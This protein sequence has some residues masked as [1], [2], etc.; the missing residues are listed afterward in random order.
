[1]S[2]DLSQLGWKAFQD[3]AAAV[4]AEVLK[5][6]VQSFLGSNDGGRDGAFLG[7]WDAA[8]PLAGKSTIQ[9][10]FLGKPGANLTLADL[11]DELP[12]AQKLAADGLADDYIVMTNAGVS[13]DADN[14]IC[15]AFESVG[16]KQCRTF[17]GGWIVKQLIENPRLRMLVPRVYGIGDLSHVITGH[18]YKQAQAILNSMGSDLSCFV[19]TDAYR[20]AVT[21]LQEHGFVILLGDPASGKSTIAAILALGAIDD[22]CLG[23]LKINSPD[24][25]SLW[26]PGEK[27]FL[28]VDDAFGPNNFDAARMA[29]WNAQLGAL[30]AAVEGGARVVFTSRNYI[31]EAARPHLK[32]SAFPLFKES[33]V[34][35]NVHALSDEERAQMLYNHVRRVQPRE[36]RQRLKPFLPAVAS[37][38][39]FLPETA[40]RLGDPLFTKNLV[41]SRERL[42]ELVEHPVEFLA[43]VLEQ[44]DDPSRAAVALVFLNS[45]SGVPSPIAETPAMQMVTRLTGVTH[46]EI[47]RAMQ[48]LN[49][50]ITRLISEDDGD[51]WI[52]RHPTVADAFATLV[53]PSPE[54]IELYVHGAKLDRLL[55]DAACRQKAAES[56]RIRIPPAL[57]PALIERLK[58]HPLDDA[59]MWFL[60]SQCEKAFLERI[61]DVRP[62]ILKWAEGAAASELVLGGRVLFAAM[63]SWSLFPET[64][65]KAMVAKIQEHSISWLNAKPLTNEVT[66]QIFK[67][68][69]F[70]AY[71]AAFKKAWLS[72]IP[73]VFSEFG[74]YSS[75]DEVGLYNEFKENLQAAQAYFEMED[76]DE[77]DE[78]YAEIDAHIESLGGEERSHGGGWSSASMKKPESSASGT[79][80]GIFKDVDD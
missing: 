39:A 33:Q 26:H 66:R 73:S 35:V 43:E 51:R 75:E 53:G 17:D 50:S 9:C 28:W 25:L 23:A 65:R 46:A 18:G 36:I 22:G 2:F 32:T 29:G 47:A 27:Q 70:A 69:E 20:S 79:A 72:D 55:E 45:Q 37:N 54:L 76:N 6:P 24:Q 8:G 31:W 5:R 56:G 14:Q 71:E 48:H 61:L 4:A 62:D 59:L 7:R 10:K 30:R 13:G 80:A 19:P 52:F 34:V 60:G 41:I 12:K 1:M 74:R 57:Y 67:D 77:F 64:T 21:A 15:K 40:R 3:L 63:A 16:V 44:L 58:Q 49:D 38:K 42:I 11:K 78:L 68:D